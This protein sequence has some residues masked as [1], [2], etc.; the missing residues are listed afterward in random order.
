MRIAFKVSIVSAVIFLVAIVAIPINL[1]TIYNLVGNDSVSST[2]KDR[3]INMAD[4]V[5]HIILP[6]FYISPV[7]SVGS[8]V[9][10]LVRRSKK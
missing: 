9:H 1:S 2:Q 5:N 7:I 8:L 4:K 3:R 6:V 10:G